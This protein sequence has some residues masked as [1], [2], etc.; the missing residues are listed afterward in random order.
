MAFH[1][2]THL[3]G[4]L[5]NAYPFGPP[6]RVT[7]TSSWTCVDHPVTR[8]NKKKQ[9]KRP[10][11]TRS[12]CGCG[13]PRPSAS[14][15]TATRR[16]IMQKARRHATQSDAPT[17][18]RR[19]VS[20]SLSPSCA[21]C[22]SPFPHGTGTLSVSLS[23]QPCRMVPADS[24]GISRAPRYSGIRQPGRKAPRTGL[25]PSA[26]GVSTPFPAPPDTGMQAALQP[27]ERLNATRFGLL[28]FR[29]PLLGES[30]TYFLL[31]GVLR[32]FSSPGAPPRKNAGMAGL[33]P[34]GL[35]HSEIRASKAICAS[36]RLVAA[37]H[38]LH[39][40]SEPRHPPCALLSLHA[41]RRNPRK[42]KRRAGLH[43]G[44]AR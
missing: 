28:P 27:R 23:I 35:P 12:R 43:G 40:L 17:A 39:R 24:R 9:H 32:C 26:A 8:N 25:S 2:H 15:A 42:G 6:S 34:A 38:V 30:L 10:V 14:P 1:P 22:F 33:Q 41:G 4:K 3:I 18:R 19:T 37:C 7:G 5:F 16:L 20:G 36:A 29:S 13:T 11:G 44:P 31:L 21:E